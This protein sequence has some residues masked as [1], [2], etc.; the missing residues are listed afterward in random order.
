[1]TQPPARTGLTPA[2][3]ALLAALSVNLAGVLPLF[4]TGA[5]AVQIGRDLRLDASGIGWTLAAMA[6]VSFLFSAPIGARIGR[7]G[8]SRSLRMAAGMSA[9]AL[10]A[11][12]ASG[13]ALLL[14]AAMAIAGIANA[15]GQTSSNALVAARVRAERFGLAYAIKQS[16]IPLAILLGGLAVPTIALTLHWRAAYVLAAAFAVVAAFLV[17]GKVHPTEGRAEQPVGRPERV[18]V[19]LLSV[20]LVAAVIAATSIGAH[21][22]SSAVAV[23]FSEGTA[24]LLVAAGGLSGL[25]VRLAAGVR[26]DRVVGGALVAAAV[27]IVAGAVGWFLMATLL[28]ALFLLGLLLA[29]AFGWGWP[30]LIHLAVARRFPQAT[31]AASGITQ[32]GVSLG[33]LIGPPMIGVIAVSRGW[34]WAWATAAVAALLG[35]GLILVARRRLRATRP[36]M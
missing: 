10:L 35:A 4:L 33:L 29:N 8:I 34:T 20:G 14:G 28:P 31:A 2:Q 1:M 3:R 15:F 23:G 11:S 21:A 9:I 16:A 17:P 27:L 13:N 24:G 19:W 7:V 12:A 18:S 30:G 32:T 36:A 26:A 5:M 22:A 6:G 25:L